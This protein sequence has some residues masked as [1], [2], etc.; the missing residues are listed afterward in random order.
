MSEVSVNVDWVAGNNWLVIDEVRIPISQ[1][2]AIALLEARSKIRQGERNRI[3]Q[4]IRD[5]KQYANEY[6]SGLITAM[7]R[8]V[9]LDD[10]HAVSDAI[11][12]AINEDNK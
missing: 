5:R 1:S 12:Y 10:L 2:Q 8:Q 11:L 6:R 7:G 9:N 3:E 4:L